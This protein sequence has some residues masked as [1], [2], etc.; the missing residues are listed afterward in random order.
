ME[1]IFKTFTSIGLFCHLTVSFIYCPTNFLD[2]VFA[3][4]RLVFCYGVF[5]DFGT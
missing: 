5:P 3:S 2:V 1:R 4:H